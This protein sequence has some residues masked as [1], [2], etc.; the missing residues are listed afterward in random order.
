MKEDEK[1]EKKVYREFT[2]TPGIVGFKVKMG[3][4]EASFGDAESLGMVIV[5][6]LIINADQRFGGG[7]PV[8][9]PGYAWVEHGT[10]GSGMSP[11]GQAPYAGAAATFNTTSTQV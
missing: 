2:V 8:E 1:K 5:E 3:C 9:A 4:T 11:I 10:G 6:Y 7:A